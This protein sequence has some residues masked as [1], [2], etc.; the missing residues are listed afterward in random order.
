[1]Y[2]SEEFQSKYYNSLKD[3]SLPAANMKAIVALCGSTNCDEKQLFNFMGNNPLSPFP[4]Q[5]LDEVSYLD[6]LYKH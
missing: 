6:E 1:M 4:I 3:V 2:L 5:Y